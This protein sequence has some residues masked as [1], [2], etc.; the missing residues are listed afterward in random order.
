MAKMS[1]TTIMAPDD[2]LDRLRAIAREEGVSL[3]AVIR[4]ALEWRACQ[5]RKR[6][7]SFIGAVESDDGPGDTSERVDEILDGYY[8]S[9]AAHL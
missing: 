6:P 5:R 8:R 3:G 2:L 4:E 9:G 7:P 1:R